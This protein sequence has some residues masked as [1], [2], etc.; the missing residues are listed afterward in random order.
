MNTTAPFAPA[1]TTTAGTEGVSQP[2]GCLHTV[3][4]IT[5]T[6]EP[7]GGNGACSDLAAD[8][9][10]LQASHETSA[11]VS[12]SVSQPALGPVHLGCG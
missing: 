9:Q 10:R 3:T 4:G 7:L 5:V 6:A 8:L 11:S 1:V 12:L 2:C